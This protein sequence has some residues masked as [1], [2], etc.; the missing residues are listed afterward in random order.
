MVGLTLQAVIGV[1]YFI[2]YQYSYFKYIFRY[3]GVQNVYTFITISQNLGKVQ[4]RK[5][6]YQI[7]FGQG[8]LDC[9]QFRCTMFHENG[10]LT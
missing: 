3:S 7:E 1:H 9:Q 2:F 5:C 4:F 6:R 10:S 8:L